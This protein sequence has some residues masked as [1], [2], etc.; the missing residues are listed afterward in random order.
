[1]EEG[2]IVAARVRPLLPRERGAA[3]CARAVDAQTMVVKAAMGTRETPFRFDATFDESATQTDVWRFT[4]PLVSSALEGFNATVFAYGQTGTGKTHTMLGEL[5]EDVGACARAG[6]GVIPRAIEKIFAHAAR[7]AASKVVHKIWCTYLEIYNERVFDMLAS[8]GLG[9]AARSGGGLEVREDKAQG[10]FVPAAE[11]VLCTTAEDVFALLWRGARNRAVAAT[12]MNDYSSRSHT[13]F[14]VMIERS[15]GVE[16]GAAVVTRAKLNLVDLAGS[17]RTA[18]TG[19]EGAA[20]QQ[21]T[22]II[23]TAPSLTGE[24]RES[25]AELS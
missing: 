18:R 1:M 16:S 3:R 9:D 17:E 2:I 8:D 21:A 11:K 25:A 6:W 12:E 15:G 23:A 7:T 10:I 5:E 4:C 14:Q 20:K 19:V 24:V 22:A 13:V